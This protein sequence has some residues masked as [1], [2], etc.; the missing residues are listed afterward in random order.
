MIRKMSKSE[1]CENSKYLPVANDLISTK[2]DN[3]ASFILVL[4][5]DNVITTDDVLVGVIL[6]WFILRMQII[7][8]L[9]VFGILLSLSIDLAGSEGK[10]DDN[11]SHEETEF[12]SSK[13]PL[14][15]DFSNFETHMFFLIWL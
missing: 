12:A 4:L 9:V 10:N 6:N 7:L 14:C 1:I 3:P 8:L 11:Y 13:L 15:Q 5:P 2:V